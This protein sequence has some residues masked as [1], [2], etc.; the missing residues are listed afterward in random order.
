MAGTTAVPTENETFNIF[1][2]LDAGPDAD[3]DITSD[4]DEEDEILTNAQVREKLGLQ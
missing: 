3:I 4:E 2:G 1:G